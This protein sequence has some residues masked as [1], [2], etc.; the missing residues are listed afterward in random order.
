MTDQICRIV[1]YILCSVEMFLVG[2]AIFQD[3]VREKSRYAAMAVMYVGVII[4]TVLY[5][6][7][8]FWIE[9]GLNIAIYIFLFQGRIARR[10]ARFWGVYLFV[11]VTESIVSAIG[12]FLMR[13]PLQS[14]NVSAVRSEIVR[15]LFAAA[16]F[17][18]TLYIVR[19][20]WVQKL[21]AS[22]RELK[23]YQY[24][25]VVLMALSSMCLLVI[26]ELL[27]EYVRNSSEIGTM[28]LILLIVLL[29]T[30]FATFFWLA[31]SIYSRNHYLRQ[32]QIKEEVINAQ[33]KYYQSIYENDNELRKF[34]H[35]IRSQL[36]CLQLL[37]TEGKTEQAIIYLKS[38]GH[39]LEEMTIQQFHTGND[40]LDAVVQQKWLEA[41]KKGIRIDI[42]GSMTKP[43]F[44]DVYELCILFSNALDNGIEACEN[45]Q[46]QKKVI[47]VS[48]V[49]HRK[50]I[51]FQIT[52]PATPEMY[53]VLRQ[54]RTGK[55]DSQRHGFGVKSIQDVVQKN[56]GEMDYRWEEGILT[57]EIYLAI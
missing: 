11:S 40:I 50:V 9:I 21:I 24:V 2:E 47:T 26:I 53:E 18:F 37:L 30:T 3:R 10:L 51:F 32:N 28:V 15:L 39:H 19:R 31:S 36:G 1:Y 5:V 25:A 14:I 56:G 43:D 16:S 54:G 29:G 12:Y 34:R 7:D 42:E 6:E 52:N 22:F 8:H 23:W 46:D 4:P 13:L 49:E 17:V 48:I 45:L 57:L 27:L 33:R 55:A 44:M 20:K 41:K 38:M 35:D